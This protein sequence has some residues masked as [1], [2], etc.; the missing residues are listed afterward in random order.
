MNYPGQCG[1][2]QREHDF[3]DWTEDEERGILVITHGK[4]V[5]RIY[6]VEKHRRERSCK[7]CKVVEHDENMGSSA[8]WPG[9]V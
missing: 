1:G 9:G 8:E 4:R 3:G 2:Y 7:H 5:G 6:A